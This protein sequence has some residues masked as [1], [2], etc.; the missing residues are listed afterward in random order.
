MDIVN[1]LLGETRMLEGY[2]LRLLLKCSITRESSTTLCLT[3]DCPYQ[4]EDNG[5]SSPCV[6]YVSS[7]LKAGI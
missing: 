3:S 1:G 5:M 6:Q 2:F 4:K 7:L